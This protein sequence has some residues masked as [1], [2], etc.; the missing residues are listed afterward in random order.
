V[1]VL[2]STG[3]AFTGGLTMITPKRFVGT[4]AGLLT[5]VLSGGVATAASSPQLVITSAT[6]DAANSRLVIDG[7]NFVW[8]TGATSK[9]ASPVAV[10]LD[11]LPLTVLSSSSTEVVASVAGTFPDGT[12]L[13]TVSRGPSATESASFA[14]AIYHDDAPQ[15]VQGP[16]GP[17]GPAGPAGPAGPQGPQG[18]AG[19]QG[20][21]GPQG[22]AGPQ[23]AMG[24]AGADGAPGPQGPAGSTGPMGPMGPQG[25]QGTA[26]VSG[27][28][29][30]TATFSG[31]LAAG[32]FMSA[33]ATCPAGTRVLAGGF[34]QSP[35]A[36]FN[37]S[38]TPTKSYPNTNQSW[39]VEF[40]N[41]QAF[42]LPTI[43][44]VVYAICAIAN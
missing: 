14:V 4:Y 39:L 24:P 3:H 11:L 23:G 19:P 42:S 41:T 37:V 35:P 38:L 8:P 21:T 18:P 33:T 1:I 22:A 40:R 15:V 2:H 17:E 5:L 20:A 13:I 6:F 43:N 25:P 31:G 32:Q 30:A 16:P 44:M 27:Y 12:Y 36:G 34:T 26:G 28:Q 10:T 29:I 9:S 7:Q